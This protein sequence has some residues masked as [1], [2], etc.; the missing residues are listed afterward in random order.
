MGEEFGQGIVG[1]I[2]ISAQGLG[3]QVEEGKTGDWK[4]LKVFFS[5]D[6]KWMLPVQCGLQ[7]LLLLYSPCVWFGNSSSIVGIQRQS[8]RERWVVGGECQAKE[9]HVYDLT[10]KVS[11]YH[12]C[13][14]YL[15]QELQ[16]PASL[17]EENIDPTPTWE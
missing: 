2:C 9:D 3:S 6:W 7:F 4:T 10:M 11:Y 14:A 8:S 1:T 17:R 15:S 12:V 16:S 13:H 5:L